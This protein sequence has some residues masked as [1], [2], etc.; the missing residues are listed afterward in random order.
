M[1]E[2]LKIKKEIVK[3]TLMPS[4]NKKI[5]RTRKAKKEQKNHNF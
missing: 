4:T 2:E 5:K 1:S 3:T